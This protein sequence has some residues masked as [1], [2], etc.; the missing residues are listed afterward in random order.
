MPDSGEEGL[1]FGR[2][3]SRPFEVLSL[4]KRHPEEAIPEATSKA[5]SEHFTGSLSALRMRHARDRSRQT[6]L[7]P[8][9]EPS[10]PG[11][12]TCP[13]LILS[14]WDCLGA[15]GHCAKT[16]LP[17]ASARGE[18]KSTRSA[19]DLVTDACALWTKQQGLSL[20]MQ[21][22][23][24]VTRW[25]ACQCLSRPCAESL[26]SSALAGQQQLQRHP[27]HA[28]P[29]S[30]AQGHSLD[31]CPRRHSSCASFLLCMAD[32]QMQPCQN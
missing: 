11:G 23:S 19:L 2:S 10:L 12:S 28:L 16:I 4:E 8:E 32:Q 22:S 31:R 29:M 5:S 21:T 13:N 6:M 27:S 15:V 25:L 24:P 26:A 18:K 17:T 20:V 7:C 30:K 3:S 14:W 9:R 1:F